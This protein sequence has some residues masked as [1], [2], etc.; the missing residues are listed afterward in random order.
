MKNSNKRKLYESIMKNVSHEVKRTLNK[1]NK[2]NEAAEF[3]PFVYDAIF[4]QSRDYYEMSIEDILKDPKIMRKVAGYIIEAR[5]KDIIRMEFS[6]GVGEKGFY[7]KGINIKLNDENMPRYVDGGDNWW[8]FIIDNQK[9]VIK[10]FQKGK[11]YSNVHASKNQVDNKDQ[12]TFMLIEYTID[13]YDGS[14]EITGIAVVDGSD[15]DFDPK[16]NRF[17]KNGNIKFIR[18]NDEY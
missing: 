13:A 11:L 5:V 3:S 15:M 1:T 10:S 14:I 9:V 2:L 16:Y 12:L 18:Y 8:D 7:D 17:V 6:V 4:G